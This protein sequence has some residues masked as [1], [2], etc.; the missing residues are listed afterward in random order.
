MTDD[1][2]RFAECLRGH[3]VC[4]V[5]RDP[6][7]NPAPL[8]GGLTSPRREVSPA[9]TVGGVFE[10]SSRHDSSFPAGGHPDTK[11]LIDFHWCGPNYL[12]RSVE[13]GPCPHVLPPSS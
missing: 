5:L 1:S 11:G 12:G 2:E 4:E 3:H 7:P 9:S 6:P 13:Q 8:C 10:K